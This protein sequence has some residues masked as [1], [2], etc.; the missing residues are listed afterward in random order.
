MCVGR[1]PLPYLSPSYAPFS[2][3][4]GLPRCLP[5]SAAAPR[6]ASA[7][8]RLLSSIVMHRPARRQTIR[9]AAASPLRARRPATR[10][11]ARPSGP[12]SPPPPPCCPFSPLRAARLLRGTSL[13][14]SACLAVS[15]RRKFQ[16]LCVAA[17]AAAC[18]RLAPAG[19]CSA[20]VASLHG[21]VRCPRAPP[22]HPESLCCATARPRPPS[23]SAPRFFPRSTVARIDT[24]VVVCLP[25]SRASAAIAIRASAR[26][27]CLHARS[28]A[29]SLPSHH[30]LDVSS[31]SPSPVRS[32]F[33][34]SMGCGASASKPPPPPEEESVLVR[35]E[36]PMTPERLSLLRQIFQSLDLDGDGK[37]DLAEFRVGTANPTMIK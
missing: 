5:R 11:V 6:C 12:A 10:T 19:Y 29:C 35:R 20:G 13:S 31:S 30:H 21:C 16:L 17:L 24:A 22:P 3:R 14:S 32:P 15:F 26:A 27:S 2:F 8:R 36:S 23:G 34:R 28:T 7:T 18:R 1:A 9:R 4:A 33:A 37:V 25:G